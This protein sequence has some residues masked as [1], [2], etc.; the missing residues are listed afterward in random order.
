[1]SFIA[2]SDLEQAAFKPRFMNAAAAARS[3]A[4]RI[5]V[6]RN[7]IRG[8]L[9]LRRHWP[10]RLSLSLS[11]SLLAA[12]SPRRSFS[13]SRRD[14]FYSAGIGRDYRFMPLLSPCR[15][16]SFL[17]LSLRL[18]T[19]LPSVLTFAEADASFELATRSSF[20]QKPVANSNA[21][22]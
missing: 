3:F 4:G 19:A 20:L 1:V 14:E 5:A 12:G 13:F 10:P 15:A 7:E 11:L 8:R 22:G 2:V 18:C 17:F 9:Y 21:A 16:F 6:R